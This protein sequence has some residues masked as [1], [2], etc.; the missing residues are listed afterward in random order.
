MITKYQ[1]FFTNRPTPEIAQDLLG[2]LLIYHGPQGIVS[3]YIVETEAYLGQAD[4][5][6]HAFKGRRTAFTEPLY[7]EPG[8]IYIYQ[9]HMQYMFDIAVQDKDVPQGVL[10]RAIQPADGLGI[11]QDNRPVDGVNITN[12][13]GKLMQAL[14]IQSKEMNMQSLETADITIALDD[15]LKKHPQEILESARIGV[16]ANGATGQHP[17]RFYVAHN[18]YVSQMKKREMDTTTFGWDSDEI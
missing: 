14:G 15:Q 16:N 8:T 7:G 13:P 6:A 2:R 4:S 5:A 17:Y 9:L 12:G 10:I 1:S 11:M 3:G 18:P